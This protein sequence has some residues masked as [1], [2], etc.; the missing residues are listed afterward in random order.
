M[1][2]DCPTGKCF[3]A[4]GEDENRTIEMNSKKLLLT[5]CA[6]VMAVALHAAEKP[7]IVFILADDL[8]Y[9]DVGFV[10]G[11]E[12]KTPNLDK[13]AAAGTVLKQFYVQP[14]CTPTR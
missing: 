7:D 11:K 3:T 1:G 4:H 13:L 8:G 14:V 9:N 2:C 6:A 5:V 10:G 12:I